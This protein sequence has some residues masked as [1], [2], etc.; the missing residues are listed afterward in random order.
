MGE[1]V[2]VLG[3]GYAGSVAV[4]C[5]ERELADATLTWVA[6]VDHHLVLHEVH[7]AIR[8]PSV[9][10]KIT[11]PVADVKAPHTTFLEAE[12]LEV[13]PEARCVRFAD[14]EPIEYDYLLVCLGSDTAFYG[15]PGLAERSH[16]LKRLEDA[17]AINDAI[18]TAGSNATTSDHAEVVV[19]G[20]GLSG[21]QTAGEIAELRDR[22]RLP[23]DV[24]I[25]EALE[26]VLP[27]LDTSVQDRVRSMLDASGITVLTDDP[28]TEADDEGLHF[29]Q[30]A[31]IPYDVLIW[32]GGITG[33]DALSGVEIDNDHERLET[34]TTF[35]TSDERVFAVGDAAV[36]GLNGGGAAPP[37][38]QAA[39]DAAA[40]AARNVVRAIQEEP[41]DRWSYRDKGTLISVGES[42]LAHEVIGIP[43]STFGG[44][45]A[46]ALKKLVAARWIA[47]ITSWR[48]GLAAWDAL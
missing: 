32:T 2:V 13:D 48:R 27:G 39:W 14:E 45:F 37:T 4:Q 6:D 23:V 44:S 19:G 16:T 43:V 24:T 47:T 31:S 12:V 11:V 20:A 38:A 15:I 7:R 33:R 10:E 36:V 26:S 22:D 34:D 35:R 3:A 46:V 18:T 5:L 30:R 9:A 8:D 42:A 1:R 17:L 29:D 41:L 21:V 28:V 25:V 40:V